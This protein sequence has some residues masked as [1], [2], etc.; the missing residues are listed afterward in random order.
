MKA[1]D[2]SQT[3]ISR[4]LSTPGQ[5]KH[6]GEWGYKSILYNNFL[7]FFLNNN[8][9]SRLCLFCKFGDSPYTFT[10][11]HLDLQLGQA[12]PHNLSSNKEYSLDFCRIE[13]CMDVV[14][15]L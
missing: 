7:D 15:F 9:P 4:Y 10:F 13:L 14:L 2:L 12:F 6:T 3:S 11:L 1:E 8:K 5:F